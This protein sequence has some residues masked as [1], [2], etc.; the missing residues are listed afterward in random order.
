[1]EE[2][3]YTFEVFYTNPIIGELDRSINEFIINYLKDNFNINAEWYYNEFTISDPTYRLIGF[4]LERELEEL[5][6]FELIDAL[7]NEYDAFVKP[8]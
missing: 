7:I 3:F 5:E 2:Q 1:M 4:E 8:Q 6:R